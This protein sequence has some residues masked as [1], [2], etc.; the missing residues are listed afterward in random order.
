MFHFRSRHPRRLAGVALTLTTAALSAV[1]FGA[2][3]ASAVVG[4]EPTDITNVPWQVSLQDPSG[5]H[6]CG[7]SILSPTMILTAAHCTVGTPASGIIVRAGATSLSAAGAQTVSVANIFENPAYLQG[8]A[9][10]VSVLVLSQPLV[11]GPGVAP[12]QLASPADLAGATSATTSGWGV[13]SETAGDIPDGLLVTTVP[14]VDDASC[15]NVLDQ[16]GGEV[17]ASSETCAGG[18]G[19]DSCYGDSGGPLV[20]VDAAGVPKLAGV[21]S[22]GVE[23]GGAAPGVY[24]EVPALA[25]WITGITP[26]TPPVDRTDVSADCGVVDPETGEPAADSSCDDWFDDGWYGDPTDPSADDGSWDCVDAD[27]DGWCDDDGSGDGDSG[28][29]GWYDCVDADDDGWC[30]DDGSGD[31]GW[32]DCVDADDDGWCDDDGGYG[33]DGGYDDSGDD[34]SGYD[35]DGGDDGWYDCVDADDDGW[36]DE[37]AAA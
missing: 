6:F 14:L 34:D 7:G 35:D 4:G 20:V 32:Y 22:W 26:D 19:T 9:T 2:G 25:G 28:D 1:S 18:T 17:T 16:Y 36:C 31:D 3:T 5:G 12:I 21:V 29:D 33:D 23:C 11:L 24:A 8:Y 30:D 10:D 27:D 13:T 15:Q 37:D